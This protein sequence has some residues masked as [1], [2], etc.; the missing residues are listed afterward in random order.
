MKATSSPAGY[1][2]DLDWD[3]SSSDASSD[4]PS[5]FEEAMVALSLESATS[6]LSTPPLSSVS[7]RGM[8]Y[9]SDQISHSRGTSGVRT[10]RTPSESA[11]LEGGSKRSMAMSAPLD[12]VQLYLPEVAGR[13]RSLTDVL[14]L[15]PDEDGG[16]VA[17]ELASWINEKPSPFEVD[18]PANSPL[19]RP[20]P[21][22]QPF[23][24]STKLSETTS[25]LDSRGLPLKLSTPTS[26]STPA[27]RSYGFIP[28]V[29]GGN[30][31]DSPKEVGP[32]KSQPP[33]G[34]AGG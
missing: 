5:S 20:F 1:F 3:S 21:L 4:S 28:A 33:K 7:N 13:K 11:E 25:R 32:E 6:P 15:D 9:R 34:I 17:M 14:Q 24:S 19:P 27:K 18:S 8:S 31:P 10:V 30:F 12:P 23:D 22:F 2:E 16:R 26:S 29:P